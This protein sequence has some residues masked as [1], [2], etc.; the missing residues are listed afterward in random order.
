MQTILQ[1]YHPGSSVWHRMDVRWKLAG[2]GL[3]CVS[4]VLLP[5]ELPVA[6]ALAL[7]MTLLATAGIPWSWWVGRL[8][9]TGAFL[10]LALIVVPLTVPGEGWSWGWLHVSEPGLRLAFLIL[11]KTFT[12]L[13]LVLLLLAT[14][15]QEALAQGA[16]ALGMPGILV[17]LL[18]LTYRYLHL[19]YD[20]LGK[21]RIALRQRG[22]RNKLN[23]HS[24]RT[25]GHVTGT[26]LVRSHDR[27]ERVAQA[28]RC[29]GFTGHYWQLTSF[30]TR[31][32]DVFLFLCLLCLQGAIPWG[33][34][35]A[36]QI[37]W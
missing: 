34:W 4:I 5:H 16:Y 10:A 28:M 2:L 1:D 11:A 36:G 12:I 24:Y 20:D 15:R 22:Y 25:V 19:L 30:Q 3:C 35:W 7:S 31:W 23:L 14:S 33:L 9:A 17:H 37:L 32:R 6:V 26:L 21:L 29:R 8:S 27:A 13:S 18:L